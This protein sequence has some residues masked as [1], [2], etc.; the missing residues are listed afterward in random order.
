[1]VNSA[2]ALMLRPGHLGIFPDAADV[3]FS[4]CKCSAACNRCCRN[5]TPPINRAARS[6]GADLWF[7]CVGLLVD[8]LDLVRI[9]YT[10][11]SILSIGK[12][13]KCTQ[14]ILYIFILGTVLHSYK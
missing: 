10:V 11:T 6:C 8:L 13:N 7:L 12:A 5:C 1:M 3:G 4:P 2:V 14:Y 9:L